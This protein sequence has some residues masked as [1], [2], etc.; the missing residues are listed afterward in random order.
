MFLFERAFDECLD[1]LSFIRRSFDR[2]LL[3][4]CPVPEWR[5][6]LEQLAGNVEVVDPGGSFAARAAGLQIEEDH[7]DFGVDRY[8]LCVA[9]GTLDTVNDLP[10]ALQLIHRALKPDSPLVGAI[11]GGNSL[12]ALR[13]SLI[14]AGRSVGQVVARAH[15]RIEPSSLGGLLSAAGFAMPVVDIDRVTLRY[16]GLGELVRDLRAMGA[17]SILAGHS[18]ALSKREAAAIH[19]A[20][21]AQRREGRTEEQVEIL[22]FAAWKQ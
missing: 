10:L 1:R 12:P 11:A 9:V 18:G 4:G 8:D 15:P 20:F 7:F 6:R 21:H 19:A 3:I 14:E 22:H 2:A 5:H 16:Q 13:S 17:T